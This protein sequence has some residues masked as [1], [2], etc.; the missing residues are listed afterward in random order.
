MV[1]PEIVSHEGPG[2][3]AQ[4]LPR[5]YATTPVAFSQKMQFDSGID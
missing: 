4:K 3:R 2:M 1:M 5:D